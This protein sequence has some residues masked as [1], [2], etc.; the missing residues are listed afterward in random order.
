MLKTMKSLSLLLLPALLL[1][2]Q[3]AGREARVHDLL[4]HAMAA[5]QNGDT[6]RAIEDYRQALALEPSLLEAR[7]NLGAALAAASRFE[8]A[9]EEDRRVLA[10]SPS[11]TGVRMNLA[12]AFYK[13]G[14]MRSAHTELLK[15]HQA[16]PM[17]IAAAIL[18]GYTDLKLNRPEE[19]AEMLAP[20]EK[21]HASNSD[22]E[23]VYA[24]ALILSNR[25]DAGL[26]KMEAVAEAT[27]SAEA[28]TIAGSARLQRQEFKQAAADLDASLKLDPA[29]PGA[30]TLSGQAHDALGETEAAE[31]AFQKALQQNA[32]DPMANLYLGALRLK[33]HDLQNARP[34]LEL[35]LQL[36]PA[37]PQARLQMAKLNSMEGRYDEAATALEALEKDDPNWLDPHVELAAVYYRLHR[38]ED[39]QREREQVRS[40]EEHQPKVHT[41]KP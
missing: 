15:I 17:D 19:A 24:Y 3:Q 26:P 34:L 23:Y 14:D 35:A 28:W 18:L 31:L 38:P 9:I 4:N 33:Q 37:L 1:P 27:R 11:N 22:L 20:L 12:L 10:A 16:R 29:F 36:Q 21:T 6:N 32:M 30:N 40:L 8:E 13:K 39:G 41:Q 7:A 25:Q 5:Q 2:A